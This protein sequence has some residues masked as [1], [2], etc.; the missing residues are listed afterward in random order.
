MQ[1]IMKILHFSDAHIGVT[2]YGKLDGS[3][4]N[5]RVND[6]LHAFDCIVDYVL[7]NNIGCV[8]FTGDMFHRNTPTPQYISEVAA[9]L[10]FIA[11][12][13]PI[14]MIP[15]NHDQA[16]FRVSAL[17][18]LEE[19]QIP[20]IH[21]SDAACS[22]II[23]DIFVGAIPYPTYSMFGIN[24]RD[25]EAN[26]KLSQYVYDIVYDWL[27]S[28]EAKRASYRIL[29]LHGNI[30]GAELGTYKKT[31]VLSE[32]DAVHLIVDDVYGWDYVALGHIHLH[33]D[34][35]KGNY[36]PIVYAGSIERI[37]FGE[38]VEDKGFVVLDTDTQHYTFVVLPCRP[39]AIL[40]VDLRGVDA[41]DY[42]ATLL[43]CVHDGDIPEDALLKVIIHSDSILYLTEYVYDELSWVHR[44]V[45]VVYDIPHTGTRTFTL[46]GAIETLSS[47]ELLEEYLVSLN[48]DD[49]MIDDV[50]D[51][52]D[53]ILEEV[54]E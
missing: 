1:A 47:F 22:Y 35:N 31:Y 18:F 24:K 16:M 48:T 52:F 30:E 40:H 7:H 23:G 5:D 17:Q 50:L 29:M 11:D 49:G 15:G 3:G 36:P 37:D 43:Q 34:V 26:I 33:Q 45:S 46:Q 12:V 9:R 2:L 39:M 21:I 20:N 19:L 42:H 32:E 41:D 8:L 28:K 27:D 10:K 51:I 13:C 25:T 54:G 6:F 44:I 14:I 38:R 53:E 4:L